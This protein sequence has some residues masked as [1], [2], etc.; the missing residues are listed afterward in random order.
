MRYW[1]RFL[2]W[3]KGKKSN[4]NE[5]SSGSD[6]SPEVEVNP[7]KTGTRIALVRGH[8]GNDSGAAGNGTTEV[9]YNS[10]VMDYVTSKTTKNVKVFK[11]SSSVNA[12]ALS[13][14]F[15]PEIV[16]QMHL[17]AFDGTAKGCEVL[18]IKGDTKS[19]PLAEKFA[20]DFTKKFNRVLRRSGDKGKKILSSGDRGVASLVAS[21]NCIK[22]LV[23][24]FFIDNRSDFVSKEEYA[25]FLL[26]WIEAL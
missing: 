11:G 2:E 4:S 15:N 10:W 6:T 26:E 23:E 5:T 1:Y 8:G 14:S 24:P 16:I 7:I 21:G 3:L 18:V 20:A 13:K 25:Q 17:N 9:A 12:V 22:F 19:Y